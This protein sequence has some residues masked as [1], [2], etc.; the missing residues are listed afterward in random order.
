MRHSPPWRGPF[1]L[2][3]YVSRQSATRGGTFRSGAGA[4]A[5]FAAERHVALM[6]PHEIVAISM[7]SASRAKVAAAFKALRYS[8]AGL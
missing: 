3:I 4:A 6:T 8:D 7:L 1:V 2:H 5:A